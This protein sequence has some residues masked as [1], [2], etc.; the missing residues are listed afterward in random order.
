MVP[1]HWGDVPQAPGIPSLISSYHTNIGISLMAGH[2]FPLDYRVLQAIFTILWTRPAG[3]HPDLFLYYRNY[4]HKPQSMKQRLLALQVLSSVTPI[5]FSEPSYVW[6]SA[7]IRP[8]LQRK[9]K[10]E[11]LSDA[12]ASSLTYLLPIVIFSRNLCQLISVGLYYQLSPPQ[13]GALP[14]ILPIRRVCSLQKHIWN[15]QELQK[16]FSAV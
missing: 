9:A 5:P 12:E 2:L 13:S 16:Y 6:A 7:T 10:R 8:G 15:G 14:Q 11:H 1:L 3:W 4:V